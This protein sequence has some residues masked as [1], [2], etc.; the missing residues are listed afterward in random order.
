MPEVMS[1]IFSQPSRN[2]GYRMLCWLDAGKIL[3]EHCA[4]I[5]GLRADQDTLCTLDMKLFRV[6]V[7]VKL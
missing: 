5:D 6:L 1:D 2:A 4:G 7:V 3:V